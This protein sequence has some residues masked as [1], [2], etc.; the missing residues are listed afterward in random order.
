MHSSIQKPLDFQIIYI[1]SFSFSYVQGLVSSEMK[2]FFR[3]FINLKTGQFRSS[4]INSKLENCNLTFYIYPGY[5]GIV[6]VRLR[7]FPPI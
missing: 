7:N 3:S 4:E 6:N 1:Y 2:N 5:V